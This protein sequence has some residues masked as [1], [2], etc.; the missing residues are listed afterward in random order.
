MAQLGTLQEVTKSVDDSL[1]FGTFIQVRQRDTSGAID[2][3]M[4]ANGENL[5]AV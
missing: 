1:R 3:D 4:E 5:E 2:G